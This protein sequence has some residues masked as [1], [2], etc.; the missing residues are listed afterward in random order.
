MED[1]RGALIGPNEEKW[2]PKCS[3]QGLERYNVA[4]LEGAVEYTVIREVSVEETEI[5]KRFYS[6]C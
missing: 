3:T 4:K 1:L 5:P 6:G 2:R